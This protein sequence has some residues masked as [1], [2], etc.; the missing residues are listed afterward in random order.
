MRRCSRSA[1]RAAL[2]FALPLPLKMKAFGLR[3]RAALSVAAS[4]PQAGVPAGGALLGAER[5]LAG[6]RLALLHARAL[7]LLLVR[8]WHGC[9]SARSTAQALFCCAGAAGD[10]C[11][12]QHRSAWPADGIRRRLSAAIGSC[13]PCSSAERF[14]LA[15]LVHEPSC[16]VRHPKLC[17]D[18][19][20]AT[21]GASNQESSLVLERTR[22]VHATNKAVQQHLPPDVSISVTEVLAIR[23]LQRHT[24][25][26]TLCVVLPS[27]V[28]RVQLSGRM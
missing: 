25:E 14:S 1:V 24:H 21:K 18:G 5:L 26:E 15:Q 12:A 16:A 28:C 3:C 10:G 27:D 7:G 9:P 19:D 20:A 2:F 17:A 4:A 6:V 13:R 23:A 8:A 11:C 22:S